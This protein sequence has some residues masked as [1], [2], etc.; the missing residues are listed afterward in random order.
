MA[1]DHLIVIGGS[2]G[3]VDALQ[4]IVNGL[5]ASLPAAICIVVHLAPESPGLVHKVLERAGSLPAE[6]AADGR[7]LEAGR[8]YVA[9]VDQHLLVEPNA[10]RLSRGP[11][12]NMFRPAVDPLFRSAAQVYGP[13]VIGVILSGG[14][15]DGTAGLWAVK[16]L[17][18]MTIVQEPADAMSTGM[19]QSAI[20][21]VAIDYRVPA[22][23]I[24][25]LLVQ[26]TAMTVQERQAKAS[27][28][29]EIEIRIAGGANARESGIE[30][31]GPPSPFAC[32]ECHGTLRELT[33]GNRTRYR[34]HTGHAYSPA[35]LST[36]IDRAIAE[37]LWNTVRAIDERGRFLLHLAQHPP[38]ETSSADLVARANQAFKD[39]DTIRAV[40]ERRGEVSTPSGT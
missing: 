18:G 30:T 37:S 32:P 17:G 4:K 34:C 27:P 39:A 15:D 21:N 26:L 3:A 28:L 7:K 25:Q 11:K 33:E 8:I 22:A 1:I 35:S 20:D 13:R 2:A 29:M 23:G 14:L 6:V 9:P 24:P 10:L 5:P 12:E 36:A 31:V 16:Q 38:G 40:A 19:P